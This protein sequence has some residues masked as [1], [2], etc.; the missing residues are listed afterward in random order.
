[1]TAM[2]FTKEQWHRKDSS[3]CWD[4]RNSVPDKAGPKGCPWS[5]NFE[6]VEGWKA[7]ETVLKLKYGDNGHY[8]KGEIGS[9]IVHECPLF[10]EG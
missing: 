9:Y 2:P 4:C 7:T 1:M 10:E 5:R 6:P 3:I 8:R